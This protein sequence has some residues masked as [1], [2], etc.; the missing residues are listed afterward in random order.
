MLRWIYR[1]MKH[2]NNFDQYLKEA[3]Q[4]LDP[5]DSYGGIEELAST[6]EF[7]KKLNDYY[8]IGYGRYT[9]TVQNVSDLSQINDALAIIGETPIQ[10]FDWSNPTDLDDFLN[11]ILVPGFY[12]VVNSNSP[13]K[14]T[15]REIDKKFQTIPTDS[16]FII[17]DLKPM[18]KEHIE[19]LMKFSRMG[20]VA[21]MGTNP[22]SFIF[23]H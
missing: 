6:L 5:Y 14:R 4:G 19:E 16:I 13:D 23:T 1:N 12:I 3:K 21:G 17:A 11:L 2:L 7:K 9:I 18:S 10:T 22:H 20:I 8:G 15:R